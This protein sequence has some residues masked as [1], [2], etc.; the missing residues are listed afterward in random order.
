M[1]LNKHYNIK[2][3]FISN[4]LP[5]L[6][7]LRAVQK[8]RSWKLKSTLDFVKK[9]IYAL[10]ASGA[11]EL[12]YGSFPI[13][14]RLPSETFC[15]MGA[16]CNANL[17]DFHKFSSRHFLENRF[18]KRICTSTTKEKRYCPVCSAKHSIFACSSYN[19]IEAQKF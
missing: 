4:I 12:H 9:V 2:N 17:K 3:Y 10:G 7:S 13:T 14:Q 8:E 5:R 1:L 15:V 11:P 16:K 6:F 18:E 19:K